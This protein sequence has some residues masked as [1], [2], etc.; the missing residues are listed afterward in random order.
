MKITGSFGWSFAIATGISIALSTILTQ[1]SVAATMS[2]DR[3]YVFG[4]SLSDVNN[5]LNLTGGSVPNQPFFEPGRFSNGNVWV[6][7]LADKLKLADAS[8]T[9]F[10]LG[11]ATTG[12]N[13][14]GL[15]GIPAGLEQQIDTFTGSL[16]GQ[17]ADK[18]ALYIVWAGANDYLGR[19]TTNPTEPVSNLSDAINT[20]VA[21]GAR[22]IL[23]PN[24]PDLG[25]IPLGQSLGSDT[26]FALDGLTR[27]HNQNLN[28]LLKNFSQ[29]YPKRKFIS[30]DVNA[31]FRQLTTNAQVND[32]DE[33]E[34]PFRFANVTSGCTNTNLYDPTIPLDP[35]KLTICDRPESY[36]F[37]DSAHPTTTAHK[38]IADSAFGVLKSKFDFGDDDDDDDDDD[39]DDLELSSTASITTLPSSITD[40]PV[41]FVP[42][43]ISASPT[44]V[45]EPTSILGLIAFG[46]FG[47]GLGIRNFLQ[48]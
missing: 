30:F 40:I 39:N 3:M 18:D 17:A 9:N 38:I 28:T 12:S 20:L 36:L 42:P 22:N 5:L 4:D 16:A 27:Q 32:D 8:V 1:T 29:T 43:V 47:V 35:S 31:L 14:V 25:K 26:A 13:N 7:Y 21:S 10:A 23:V 48:K 19:F 11:G 46:T 41:T 6:E 24:L 45:P 2:L 34:N 15:P 44:R 33:D 37:W